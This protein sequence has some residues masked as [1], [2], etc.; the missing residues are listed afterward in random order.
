LS[1]VPASTSRRP[2]QRQP[3]LCKS[4]PPQC[5]GSRIKQLPDLAV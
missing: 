1:Y 3:P 4:F 2:C 5:L